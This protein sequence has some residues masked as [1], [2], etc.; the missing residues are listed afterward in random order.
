MGASAA[1]QRR[2]QSE[3]VADMW[4]EPEESHGCSCGIAHDL[5]HA[6]NEEAFHYFL[7][8]EGRRAEISSRPVLLLVADLKPAPGVSVQI[9]SGLAQKLFAGLATCLRETDFIGWYRSERAAGA[10]L[11]QRA[12][13]L[14]VPSAPPAH[15]GERIATALLRYLPNEAA[16][17]L[18]VR[19][20]QLP[21]GAE[22]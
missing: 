12:E 16:D 7:E 5:G 21:R 14:A 17:R 10:V 8:I 2:S 6:Y 9:D 3:G 1:R 11:T 4:E 20:Y 13:A 15:V 19:L 18:Q 22:Q